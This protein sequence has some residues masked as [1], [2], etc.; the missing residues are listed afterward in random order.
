[1]VRNFNTYPPFIKTVSAFQMFLLVFLSRYC[2]NEA[3]E[4]VAAGAQ[5]NDA[6]GCK[7]KLIKPP[8]FVFPL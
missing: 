7:K 3:V 5:A 6:N 1:M 2:Y 4:D 8:V